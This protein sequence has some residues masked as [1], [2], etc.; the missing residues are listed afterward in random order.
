MG[1]NTNV[2]ERGVSL[3]GGQIQRLGIARALYKERTILVLDEATSAL[4]INTE[5][6][7]MKSLNNL[8]KKLTV[9][10]VAHRIST[11]QNCDKLLLFSNGNLK[12]YG[13]PE[14]IIPLIKG[15][16]S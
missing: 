13:N 10:I 3:S 9:F 2:G 8:N 16:G 11:V 1:F 12:S 14:E 15:Y 6:Q 7:V 4:D 5:K